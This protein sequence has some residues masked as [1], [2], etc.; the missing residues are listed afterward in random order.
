MNPGDKVA[1]KYRLERCLGQGGMGEVW[2]ATHDVTQKTLALKFVKSTKKDHDEGTHRRALREA[3]AA[4]AVSHPNVVAVHDVL[5][6]D[7]GM[8]ILVMDLLSG[9]SLAQKLAREHTLSPAET[10]RIAKEVLAALSVAHAVGVVHRDLKPD[11]V[12]LESS[13]GVKILD[14]GIAKLRGADGPTKETQRLTESGAMVGTPHYM[15][16]EQAFGE[17][18]VDLRADLFSVGAVM[19]ECLTGKL[20]TDGQ[21][22]GQILKALATGKI[23]PISVELPE[24]G[25]PFANLVEQLL[26]IEPGARPASAAVVLQALANISEPGDHALGSHEPH[27]GAGPSSIKHGTPPP[28]TRDTDPRT[29]ERPRRV[30]PWALGVAAA[31]AMVAGGLRLSAHRSAGEVS[32]EAV[33]GAPLAV[34][35]GAGEPRP[36]APSESKPES[37]ST[38]SSAAPSAVAPAA[39]AK[40]TKVMPRAAAAASPALSSS[41][42]ATGTPP[43][44]LD[45]PY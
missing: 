12:F 1:G 18:E 44:L 19:Y 40:P 3:R 29:M 33:T 25:K 15:S 32:R 8:P 13:G 30:L 11:N 4:C 42:T 26:Q 36:S 43:K 14:F 9:E 22:L 17:T 35:T 41:A 31:V 16:P 38:S 5:E 7:D 24:L 23:R 21:N 34:T 27:E 28:A 39:S 37:T 10:L 20:P 45:T 2:A 6:S